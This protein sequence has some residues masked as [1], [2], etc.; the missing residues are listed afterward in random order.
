MTEPVRTYDV[1]VEAKPETVV[2]HCNDPRFQNAFEQFIE[3]ELGL[4]KGQYMSLVAGGGPGALAHPERLP[5]DFKFMK[6]RLE[7]IRENFP[8]VRRVVLINHDDCRYYESLENR[9]LHFLGTHK[10]LAEQSREDMGT[11][12]RIFTSVLR[13]LGLTVELYYAK[14]AD[15]GHT[16]I[17]FE[18][19]NG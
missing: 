15:P 9:V 5:K 11:V 16:K 2:V 7:L 13:Y 1:A 8:T 12:G 6:D 17:T 19:V 4:A 3:K 10:T 14:F 18:R